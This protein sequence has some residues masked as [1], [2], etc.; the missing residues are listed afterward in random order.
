LVGTWSDYNI[1]SLTVADFDGDGILDVANLD[2]AS[3]LVE[4]R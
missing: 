4:I 1:D 2:R 3:A